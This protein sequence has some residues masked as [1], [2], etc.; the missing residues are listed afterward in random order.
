[1]TKMILESIEKDKF[2][3]LKAKYEE[4]EDEIGKRDFGIESL[5]THSRFFRMN[6][7]IPVFFDPSGMILLP[8]IL[9][10]KSILNIIPS[11]ILF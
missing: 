1:M 7:P 9:G 4:E 3:C 11:L 5:N 10:S 8:I 6:S 2:H